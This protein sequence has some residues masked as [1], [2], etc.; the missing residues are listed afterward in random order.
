MDIR[1]KIKNIQNQVKH[2]LYEEEIVSTDTKPVF[3]NHQ[4]TC[5]I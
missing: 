2:Y 3:Q 1:D 5:L 4:L